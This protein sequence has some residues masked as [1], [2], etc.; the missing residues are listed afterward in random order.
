[1]DVAGNMKIA[2]DAAVA[3]A[4]EGETILGMCPQWIPSL[5]RKRAAMHLPHPAQAQGEVAEVHSAEDADAHSLEEIDMRSKN[6]SQ[7]CRGGTSCRLRQDY[8]IIYFILSS[9]PRCSYR[10]IES[11][12]YNR[13]TGMLEWEQL[14]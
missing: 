11:A 14:P 4:K 2:A 5:Q 13:A 9:A 10:Q 3:V 1:V 12:Q 7:P 6:D 8:F